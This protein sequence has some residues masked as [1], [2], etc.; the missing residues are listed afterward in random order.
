MESHRDRTLAP[1]VRAVRVD[2]D[3]EPYGHHRKI[4][5]RQYAQRFRGARIRACELSIANTPVPRDHRHEHENRDLRRQQDSGKAAAPRYQASMSG[6]QA[7]ATN[8]VSSWPMT[9][10]ANNAT[11]PQSNAAADGVRDGRGQ[12]SFEQPV[13]WRYQS[14]WKTPWDPSLRFAARNCRI[15]GCAASTCAALAKR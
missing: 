13:I 2:V 10:A 1:E 5:T 3:G 6:S 15:A 12:S 7:G 4:N 11:Q 9:R 14:L 8:K